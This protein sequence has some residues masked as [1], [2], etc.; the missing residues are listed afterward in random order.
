MYYKDFIKKG[1]KCIHVPE[2]QDYDLWMYDAE[3]VTIGEHRPYYTDGTPDPT[4]DEYDPYC[5]VEIEGYT[6]WGESQIMLNSLFPIINKD[7]EVLYD[8]ERV[9]LV[10]VSDDNNYAVIKTDDDDEPIVVN[11]GDIAEIRSIND[12]TETE[13]AELR[14]Q[15]CV[16]SIYLSSYNNNLGVPTDEVYTSAESYL[17]FIESEGI[18]DTPEEFANYIY[19]QEF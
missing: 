11:G 2:E 19:Y 7:E 8:G 1:N 4:P 18:E 6:K 10:G 17:E 12:L 3:L 14:N 13:L 5:Y 9:K 15:I 16:G